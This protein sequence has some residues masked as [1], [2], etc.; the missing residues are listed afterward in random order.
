MHSRK[1]KERNWR[2]L[3]TCRSSSQ[4]SDDILTRHV[5][6][7]DDKVVMFTAASKRLGFPSL[8][9]RSYGTGCQ[10]KVAC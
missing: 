5:W 4:F 10:M 1:N 9:D 8:C 7:W 2:R 3:H 6:G